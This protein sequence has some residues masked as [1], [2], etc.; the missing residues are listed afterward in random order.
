[1]SVGYGLVKGFFEVGND[2]ESLRL[3]WQLSVFLA[4]NIM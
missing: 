3:S 1:M 4:F 2:I